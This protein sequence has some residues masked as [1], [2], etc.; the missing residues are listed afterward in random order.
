[1]QN[2]HKQAEYLKPK[3]FGWDKIYLKDHQD[4]TKA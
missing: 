2:Y 4:R 1:M 3:K